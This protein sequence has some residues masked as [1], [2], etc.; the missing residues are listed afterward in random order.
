MAIFKPASVADQRQKMDV[1]WHPYGGA[2]PVTPCR[3]GENG[4]TG[5]PIGIY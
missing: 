5:R 4:D 3:G 2:G 1:A